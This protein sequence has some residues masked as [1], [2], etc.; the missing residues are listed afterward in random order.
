MTYKEHNLQT[1]YQH[2][3]KK[4]QKVGEKEGLPHYSPHKRA[5]AML[6]SPPME[7]YTCV[8]VIIS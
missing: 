2:M 6:V 8:E 5:K 4:K 3:E 7:G 1:Y